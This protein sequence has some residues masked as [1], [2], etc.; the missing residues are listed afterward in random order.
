[1]NRRN[2]LRTGACSGAASALALGGVTMPD[3]AHA[4]TAGTLAY[5]KPMPVTEPYDVVVCGGGPSGF[6]AALAA[7]RTG[8][9]TLVIEGQAQLGGNATSGLV[10]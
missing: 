5:S 2:F 9:K 6:A 8:L 3:T 1:M 7:R 4:T 10:L